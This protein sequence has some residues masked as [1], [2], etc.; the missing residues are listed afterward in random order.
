MLEKSIEEYLVQRI[1][2]RGGECIK[3]ETSS[4]RGWP[5]RLCIL[6]GMIFFV[7]TK[8]PKGGV[9]SKYQN[10]ITEKI[11]GLGVHAYIAYTREEVDLILNELD[12]RVGGT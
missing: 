5:D 9:L 11:N 1:K 2:C 7:E 8:R 4:E 6:S 10:H 3:I 12:K